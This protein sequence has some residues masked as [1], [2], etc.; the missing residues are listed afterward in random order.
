MKFIIFFLLLILNTS[1]YSSEIK[2]SLIGIIQDENNLPYRNCYIIIDDRSFQKVKKAFIK[3]KYSSNKPI[4][5]Y[6]NDNGIFK[7]DNISEGIHY[8]EVRV[9]KN[10][11]IIKE[12]NI[13]KG[14]NYIKII[15]VSNLKNDHKKEKKETFLKK[16]EKEK[17]KIETI[18]FYSKIIVF[19]IFF[20]GLLN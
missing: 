2:N 4:I 14:K 1:I 8:I 5:G 20:I 16:R 7:I 13:K 9:S 17:E 6:T 10:K 19:A 11:K 3:K 15:I 12:F 18:M